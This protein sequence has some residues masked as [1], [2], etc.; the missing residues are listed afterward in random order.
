[1]QLMEV[2]RVKKELAIKM[3][4]A[5]KAERIAEAALKKIKDDSTL[6]VRELMEQVKL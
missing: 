3:S 1:M 4:E 6:Q 2:E 5:V